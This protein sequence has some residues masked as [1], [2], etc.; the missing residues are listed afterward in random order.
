LIEK[1][2]EQNVAGFVVFKNIKLK[3]VLKIYYWYFCVDK[4]QY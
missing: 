3:T 4:F 2:L 1:F